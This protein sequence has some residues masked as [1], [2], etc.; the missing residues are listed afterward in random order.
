MTFLWP[1]ML[2]AL[3]AIPLAAALYVASLRRRR[4]RLAAVGSFGL[5]QADRGRRLGARRHIPPALFGLALALMLVG[6]ARPQAAV[7]LPRLEGTVVLAF[8]V[9][10][11]MAADDV[12]PTR[13]D[14][15]KAAARAFVERQPASVKV[16]VVAFS[17]GGLAVQAPGNDPA[18]ILDAIDRLQPEQGTSLG[19]GLRAA[20]HTLAVNAGVALPEP[21]ADPDAQAA[22]AAPPRIDGAVIVVFSDGENTGPPEPAEVAQEAAMMGVPVHT[23]GV[24]SLDGTTLEVDG[25][26]LRTRLEAGALEQIAEIS[27]GAAYLA[28]TQADL[29]AIYDTI[30]RQLVTTPET[31]EI[32]ALFS[33][34]GLLALLAG[35]LCSL[36]WFGR[37]P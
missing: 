3:A 18:A 1:T 13:L 22:P 35:G 26:S 36:L 17:D 20:L 23:V 4:R 15:A 30:E 9:S 2:I 31:T 8:D 33:G 10:R 34:A 28:D 16:G 7:S 11:S 32:T 14:A 27:G 6:L 29:A 24:G 21:P 37:V 19:A 12:A 5:L 25:F